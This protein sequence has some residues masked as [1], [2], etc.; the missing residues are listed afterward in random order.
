[1]TLSAP[2]TATVVPT[3]DRFL[4]VV[5]ALAIVAVVVQHW[6]M[7][8]LGYTDGLL[9]AGNAFT[10]PG[11]WI[12]TWL[13][14]VMPL[15]F[16]TGGAAN[17][18][19]LTRATTARSWLSRRLSRLLL[20]VLPLLAV[21][22][23]VPPVLRLLGAPEQPVALASSIAAQLLWFLGV[24]LITVLATPLLVAAHRRWRWA[25]PAVLAALAAVVDAARFDGMP[26]VGYANAVFVWFAVHQ[27]G[28]FY[29]DGTLRRLSR[30]AALS[31]SAAG[32]GVTALLVAFGPYVA[33]MIGMPGA[34]MSNMSPPAVVLVSLAV[35][36]I[37]LTLA[38]REFL[39]TWA[40]RPAIASTLGWLGSRFMSVYLWHM[41]ALIVL[42]GV[43]VLWFDYATPLPGTITWFATAPGWLL[44]AGAI[45]A[46][47]LRVFGRFET[48]VPHSGPTSTP[49]LCVAALLGATGTLALA[50]TGF[51]SAPW[52]WIALVVCAYALTRVRSRTPVP[53]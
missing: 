13:S 14:Q 44:S 39:T 18:L 1:M 8:V 50:A 6:T 46:V 7:P 12:V 30:R 36:Q 41:P 27:L 32:F 23:A 47:L 35:G 3:R 20:P 51:S 22:T 10:T 52:P 40:E 25:V 31:V 15:V 28:F 34:P 11:W 2:R 49:R 19:S 5:R 16:F 17:H 53:A 29:S 4:D 21:W 26:Y 45:L 42:T 37:G 48:H 9:T 43:T 24:Y 33:S 38:A